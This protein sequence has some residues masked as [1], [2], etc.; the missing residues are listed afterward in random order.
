MRARRVVAVVVLAVAVVIVGALGAAATESGVEFVPFEE[1]S[2]Q[3]GA[4]AQQFLPPAYEGPGFFEWMIFPL[5]IVGVVAFAVVLARYLQ[6]QPRF[7][8]ERS[9]KLKKNKVSQA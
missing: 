8:R 7:A 9:E 4:P 2:E 1:L 3:A 5:L 6:W